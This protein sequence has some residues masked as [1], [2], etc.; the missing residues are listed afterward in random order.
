V[1]CSQSL[2]VSLFAFRYTVATSIP[3]RW[4]IEN[5]VAL[6]KRE[7]FDAF[8]ALGIAGL[9]DDLLENKFVRGTGTLRYY[10]FNW[11][12]QMMHDTKIGF[13]AL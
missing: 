8:T 5:V 11:R 9:P 2:Y 4:L 10:L 1:T 6:A 7:G 12:G 13:V 3:R